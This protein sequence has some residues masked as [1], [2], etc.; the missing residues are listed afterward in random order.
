MTGRLHDLRARVE[1]LVHPVAKAHQAHA[2]V[3]VLHL[4]DE[5]GN[6]VLVPDFSQHFQHGFVGAAMG[7]P[8]QGRDTGGNARKR[9]GPGG[10]SQTHGGCGRILFMVRVQDQDAVHGARQD[11]V[12]LVRLAGNGEHHG[13]EVFRIG[14]V[15]ARIDEGLA[16]RVFVRPCRNG[17]DL[18]DDAHGRLV[19][20][21]RVR[22]IQPFM[23]EGGQRAH[24]ATQ[25][26]HGMGVTTETVE[27]IADLFVQQGVVLDRVHKPV[28][29][30]LVRQLAVQ[31]Q[32]GHFHERRLFG[33]L[34]DGIAPMQQDA[35]F[36]INERDLAGA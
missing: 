10:T 16:L 32:I 12:D 30:R 24:R 20:R 29:L 6:V 5:F 3:L 18:G 11:G 21:G 33:Q 23:I 13:Q 36:A 26:G 1:V 31:Q 15:V 28:V 14:Q 22:D 4:G 9:V 7:R 17:R 2:A 25:D 8:P 35:L 19:A 34:R 27:E